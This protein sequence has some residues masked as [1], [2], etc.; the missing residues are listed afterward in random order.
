M[1]PYGQIHRF[2]VGPAWDRY[3]GFSLRAREREVENH[4]RLPAARRELRSWE[5]VLALTRHAL[6][7]VPF[8]VDRAAGAG[9]DPEQIR[10]YEDF[11]RIPALT[12][13]DMREA[14]DRL[15]LP[16]LDKSDLVYGTTGGTTDSPIPLWYDKARRDIKAAEMNFYRRWWGWRPWDRTLFLWG[17]AMDFPKGGTLSARARARLLNRRRFLYANKLNPQVLDAYIAVINQFK[18]RIIQVYSNPGRI[19]AGH[20][21]AT[22]ARMHRPHAVIATAEPCPPAFREIMAKAFRCPV[23]TFYGARESGYIAAECPEH[24]NLH[25]NTHS[26]FLEIVQNGRPI[27]PGR[28]G[29]VLLTD[30]FSFAMPFLRYRIGDMASLSETPCPCGRPGPILNFMAGRETDVFKTPDGDLVPGVSFCERVV[31]ECRGF[32]QMQFIQEKPDELLVKMVKGPDY[33][34]EDMKKLDA[35]LHYYFAGK[36]TIVKQFVSDIPPEP[37]GKVRFCISKTE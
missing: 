22:G 9:L 14:G 31:T 4:F 10:T 23:Y 35:A 32:A 13:P 26:L 29:Q 21:L 25:V 24:R 28:V 16:G 30:L 36:L 15:L 19:L 37:S 6:S 3:R 1:D 5:R 8:F 20:I 33:T 2:L 17:A 27:P 18:P 7:R 34:E 12:K 11:C